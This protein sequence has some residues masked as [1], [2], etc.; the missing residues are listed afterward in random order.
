[1]HRSGTSLLTKL[2]QCGGVSLPGKL[3]AGDQYNP[4]GYF[5]RADITDL[6]EQLLINLE[7]WWPSNNGIHP[8]PVDWLC[9]ASTHTALS[10]LNALLAQE[11]DQQSAPWAIKDPRTSLL[12]PLWRRLTGEL[13]IPV[14]LILA[15]RHP[16]EV[17]QSLYQRDAEA[18]GMTAQRAE[19]IWWRHN[20]SVLQHAHGLPLEVVDYS[21]WFR[22]DQA[23]LQLQRLWRFCGLPTQELGSD[24]MKNGLSQ[25]KPEHRRSAKMA[26]DVKLHPN[27]LALYEDLL[28]GEFTHASRTQRPY[29]INLAGSLVS[30]DT[31]L[32][33]SGAQSTPSS[34]P[35]A[36]PLRGWFDP[37]F[38]QRRYADL[39]HLSDPLDHYMGHGW[40]EG[41]QPHPLF[42]PGHYLQQCIQ[43][44]LIPPADQPLL[45]HFL[46]HGLSAGIMPSPLYEQSWW[47]YNRDRLQTADVP[48][49]DEVH[50]WGGAALAL[51]DHDH[52]AASQL[53]SHWKCHGIPEVDWR[54]LERG[55]VPWLR[56]PSNPPVDPQNREWANIEF[57]SIGLDQHNWLSQGWLASLTMPSQGQR[58]AHRYERLRLVLLAPGQKLPH[59]EVVAMS[60]SPVLLV[61]DPDPRRCAAWQHLGLAWMLLKQ[62]TA[63]QLDAYLTSERWL[64]TAETQLGLP[65]PSALVGRPLLTLGS[66]GAAWDSQNDHADRWCFPGFDALVLE[67][68]DTARSLAS[69]LWHC[70]RQG[71][72][73]VRLSSDANEPADLETLSWLP[74]HWMCVDG[75]TPTA[76]QWE[77]SWRK[78]GRP[79]PEDPFTPNPQ[80]NVIWQGGHGRAAAA[81]VAVV[82]SL[83]N[84]AE[85][86]RETLDS[87]AAQHLPL[88]ELIVVDDAS[89]DPGIATV[90]AWLEEH[91]QR[92]QR[93]LLLS[94]EHNS[95]LASARN[96]AFA[97][98]QAPWCLVLDADNL[99]LP[100]AASELLAMTQHGNENLAVVHPLIE[101]QLEEADGSHRST[102]L[103]NTLSWQQSVF[104]KRSEGNYI[105]AMAL[106]R[107]SA[108]LAV[109]G[110]SHIQGGWEDFDFWCLL[111]E[112]DYHGVLCPAVLAQYRCHRGSMLRKST[113]TNVRQISRLVNHRHT[114]LK[115]R[116]GQPNF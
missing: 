42:D 54:T 68:Q 40:R 86:I 104:A 14:R 26:C 52:G 63:K 77:L 17:V 45:Q 6:Q 58:V 85:R 21:K 15:V 89:T 112:A 82:V 55:A 70:H 98:A 116:L 66:G 100:Q 103:L 38:Y 3:I 76:L 28:S 20:Q 81:Q 105:D 5:E 47:S 32:N 93:A 101:Q 18:A 74:I 99:L 27:T 72:T 110:Y 102:G 109:G 7:R 65:T 4:E 64:T 56:W 113:N 35:A 73:L 24:A 37:V 92:F 62:P 69:W 78:A 1:M 43:R 59:S 10:R 115:L 114:W 108:W 67:N 57:S 49:I 90:K 80:A 96:T 60:Q 22:Q 61:A 30:S 88:L 11:R 2:L 94:H 34:P 75:L 48:T 19:L 50:P 33:K 87:V 91:D 51:A 97:A 83:Y 31:D 12:L 9:R 8:L 44:G 111:I 25:I 29:L 36:K 79:T 41:R 23:A 106:V 107:R 84:Y 95:G 53:L 71:L 16:A 39:A 46:E 13:K